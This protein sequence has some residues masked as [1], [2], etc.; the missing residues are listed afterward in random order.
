MP[1]YMLC[2]AMLF[3]ALLLPCSGQHGTAERNPSPN[4]AM[5]T[6]P[7]IPDHRRNQ[8]ANLIMLSSSH[9]CKLDSSELLEQVLHPNATLSNLQMQKQGT[10][11]TAAP[12]I[13][14]MYI[15]VGFLQR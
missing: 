8:H 5:R 6:P 13:A 15:E 14:H 11:H 12:R 7:L 10:A 3:S 9:L 4:D 2:S 1:R